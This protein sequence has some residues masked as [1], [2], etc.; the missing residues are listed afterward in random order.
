MVSRRSAVYVRTLVYMDEP[1]LLL[2]KSYK[3]HVIALA[4]PSPPE[5]ARFIATTV[6]ARDFDAYNDGHVD[7]RY[8]FTYPT[9]RSEYMFDLMKMTDNKVMMTPFDETIPEEYLPSPRFFSSSHTEEDQ[10]VAGP[11]DTQS[12]TVDGEWDMPDFGEFYSRYS[13]VYYFL[14]ASHAFTDESVDF[15]KK[16]EI[17]K[18]FIHKPFKGGFSYVHFYAALPGAVPRVE[19]LRMDKIKYE[20]PGYVTVNGDGETFSET[21]LIIRSFLRNRI[22]LRETY[23]SFYSFLSKGRYLAMAAE[24]FVNNDPAFA[25]IDATATSLAEKLNIPNI[26][27]VKLL[28]EGNPLAFAK[29]VLSLYRRLDD[30]SR[31]FAQGRVNFG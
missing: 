9:T 23:H 11:Q 12:L 25:Y 22:S 2:L 4:V 24:E 7:L 3:T 6:S 27:V 1:M 14:S 16:K 20:S 21:E 17:K 31:F 15:E 18:T 19:R 28:I 8:L 5:E 30:A 26:D 10:E 13:D 29:I